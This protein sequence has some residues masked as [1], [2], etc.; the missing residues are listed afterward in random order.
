MITRGDRMS[1]LEGFCWLSTIALGV[2][3]ERYELQLIL[4]TDRTLMS[5]GTTGWV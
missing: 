2:E 5:R 4:G 3:L 1:L